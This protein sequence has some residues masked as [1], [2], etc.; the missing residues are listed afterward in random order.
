MDRRFS[1]RLGAAMLF[2]MGVTLPITGAI[3][4]GKELRLTEA[5]LADLEGAMQSGATSSVEVTVL[6]LNR[7]MTFDRRGPKLNAVP[8]LNPRAL[9]ERRARTRCGSSGLR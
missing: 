1:V 5:S 4:V 7:I 6:Y 2:T 9:D 3:A 8:V